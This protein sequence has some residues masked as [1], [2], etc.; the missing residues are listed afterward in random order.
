MKAF[1]RQRSRKKILKGDKG[2][3]RGH[4]EAFQVAWRVYARISM[5]SPVRNIH[6][7]YS[8]KASLIPESEELDLSRT[9][10]NVLTTSRRGRGGYAA[11]W[12]LR[13]VWALS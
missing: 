8:S 10:R 5:D 13:L 3:R 12:V 4:A 2:R 9:F 6:T 1:S 11:W 7:D